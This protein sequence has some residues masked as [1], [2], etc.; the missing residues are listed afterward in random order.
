MSREETNTGA[1]ADSQLEPAFSLAGQSKRTRTAGV[2]AEFVRH[3]AELDAGA[4]WQTLPLLLV[5]G[6]GGGEAEEE[7]EEGEHLAGGP[8]KT[9]G[10]PVRHFLNR[11]PEFIS[12]SVAARGTEVRQEGFVSRQQIGES[13]GKLLGMR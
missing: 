6:G 9:D 5:G 11:Q 12:T 7:R 10:K 13:G 4:L 3:L 2:Q 8:D 1:L